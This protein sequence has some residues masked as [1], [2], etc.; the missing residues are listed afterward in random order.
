MPGY[1]PKIH[2]RRSIR[3]KG[4]DYSLEGAYFITI[5][6]HQRHN[7]FGEV[8]NGTMQLNPYGIIASE[9]WIRL[10]KRFRQSNFED[11]VIM[12][13]HIHGIICIV[14][15]V[16]EEFD[17]FSPGSQPLRPYNIPYVT[18]GSLGA[19]VR[20]YK[21]SVAFRI[22]AIRGSAAPP[23]WQQNY[24]DHIIRNENEFQQIKDYI[25]ANPTTWMDDRLYAPE[26]LK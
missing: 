15:G 12:P 26:I 1:N 16:G 8:E 5:C 20:A 24:H 21:A 4:Y 17:Q 13:N 9:Q 25:E 18:P 2:H 11:Y 19:I 3:M 14:R 22:N 10:Q 7:F 23:V 6:T